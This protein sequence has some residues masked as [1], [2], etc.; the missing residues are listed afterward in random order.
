MSTEPSS[1]A[2]RIDAGL[3]RRALEESS[4]YA[5]LRAGIDPGSY[6][7]AGVVVPVVFAPDPQ[8]LVVV[9]SSSLAEHA[10]ELGFP[11]GKPLS[12]R[13]SVRD[14][15]FPRARGGARAQGPTSRGARSALAGARGHRQ[16][17]DLTLRGLGRRGR[18]PKARRTRARSRAQRSARDLA[19]WRAALRRL[20]DVVAR[21]SLRDPAFSR[22]WPHL[23]R[24]ERP[25]LLRAPR[26]NGACSPCDAARGGAQ[27]RNARGA[28]AIPSEMDPIIELSALE[29]ARRIRSRELSPLEVVDAHIRRIERS[30]PTLERRRGS[31]LRARARRGACRGEDAAAHAGGGAPPAV[32][33]AL[34]VQG[35]LRGGGSAS[36][37]R[38]LAQEKRDRERGRRG[39]APGAGRRRHRA[40]GDERARRRAL[41]RESQPR[42][43]SHQQSLGRP[44]H[45]RRV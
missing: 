24:R 39:R 45:V 40:R 34:H 8:A 35:L 17:P 25:H 44:T 18:P 1:L 30:E 21:R 27:R 7:A 6:A 37:R 20:H 41:A 33:R 31:P 32:R 12:A 4:T 2:S 42:L 15:A 23:V 43:R 19:Q 13:E 29:L 10:G 28:N 14:A 26:A 38:P 36:D 5:E 3:I 9:R 16:V 11:G 22:R